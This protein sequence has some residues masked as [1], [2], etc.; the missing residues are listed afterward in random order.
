[1][2][3]RRQCKCR[4]FVLIKVTRSLI[5]ATLSIFRAN[6]DL[7][8]G[9]MIPPASPSS[10]SK[11]TPV[12][13]EMKPPSTKGSMSSSA[14]A[15]K[16][17]MVTAYELEPESLN[18]DIS[19]EEEEEPEELDELIYPTHQPLQPADDEQIEAL[20]TQVA[21]DT[22]ETLPEVEDEWVDD[23]DTGYFYVKITEDEFDHLEEV[24]IR[25]K[26]VAK[27]LSADI[28][29]WEQAD[30][31]L[32]KHQD[33]YSPAQKKSA[34]ASV[35]GDEEDDIVTSS[36]RVDDGAS[37]KRELSIGSAEDDNEIAF[38]GEAEIPAPV[39]TSSVSSAHH[40]DEMTEALAIGKMLS[41]GSFGDVLAPRI[42]SSASPIT[43]SSET[44]QKLGYEVHSRPRRGY[45]LQS[46]PKS[47]SERKADAISS[48]DILGQSHV[49]GV[50]GS[51]HAYFNLK[52]IFEPNTT[53]FED[54]EF[55][56]P[57]GS[58]IAGRYQVKE[59]LG[60]AAFSTALQCI[61]L[62]SSLYSEEDQWVCLKVIKNKKDFFDQ[63][64][65]EIKLLQLINSCGDPDKYNVI[66]VSLLSSSLSISLTTNRDCSSSTTFTSKNTSSSSRSYSSKL[67]RAVLVSLSD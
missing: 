36:L 59:V 67:S 14:S 25:N 42:P 7:V 34:S 5:R 15:S 23:D 54:K 12:H 44:K 53:G 16:A 24:A 29:S 63:S 49:R 48:K 1:M 19:K 32:R 26:Q 50:D 31:D 52:V 35:E 13:S 64:I 30:K 47:A 58:I 10:Q 11:H 6:E 2:R 4:S 8:D 21:A 22:A 62:E 33:L 38:A 27:K 28:N 17:A 55:S 41:N 66:R 18:H 65:D 60:Q 40:D 3:W 39:P 45:Y 61:D 20:A 43:S 9:N 51:V 46:S 56:P 57:K 37:S